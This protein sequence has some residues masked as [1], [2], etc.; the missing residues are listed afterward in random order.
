M[1]DR[2][3]GTVARVHGEEWLI[4]AQLDGGFCLAVRN[5][6]PVPAKVHLIYCCEIIANFKTSEVAI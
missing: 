6:E 2:I 4:V 1:L 5:G 3:E